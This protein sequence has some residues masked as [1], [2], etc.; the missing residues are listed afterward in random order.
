[1]NKKRQKKTKKKTHAKH[2][3]KKKASLDFKKARE[4]K[5]QNREDQRPFYH[6]INDPNNLLYETTRPRH[7]RAFGGFERRRVFGV[8]ISTF[9]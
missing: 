7:A 4:K 5:D 9:F 1:M 2:T 3:P 6:I 8:G